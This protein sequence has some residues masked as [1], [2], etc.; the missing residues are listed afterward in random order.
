MQG[1]VRVIWAEMGKQRGILPKFEEN[2]PEEE[3]MKP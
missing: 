2:E 3:W 1:D